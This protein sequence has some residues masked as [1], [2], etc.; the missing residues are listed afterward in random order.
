MSGYNGFL[1]FSFLNFYCTRIE[2][3]ST[4]E[5]SFVYCGITMGV[6]FQERHLRERRFHREH[7]FR[8]RLLYIDNT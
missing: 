5:N 7:Y 1:C 3:F 6:V 4:D 8:E 2:Q